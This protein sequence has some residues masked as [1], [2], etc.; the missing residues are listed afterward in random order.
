MELIEQINFHNQ[1]FGV[2]T[3]PLITENSEIYVLFGKKKRIEIG[4]PLTHFP[5]R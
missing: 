3:I 4:D 1:I 5:L 2:T